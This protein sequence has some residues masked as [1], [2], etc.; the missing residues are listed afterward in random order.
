MKK[1]TNFFELLGI[2][3]IACSLGLFLFARIQI[4]NT[5]SKVAD[6]TLKIEAVLPAVTPGFPGDY[7]DT[8]MPVLQVDEKDYIGL[9]KIPAYGLT[10]PIANEWNSFHVFSCPARFYGSAYDS[11]MIIGGNDQSGQFDF[12]DRMNPGDNVRI[13]DMIGSE[14]SYTVDRIDRSQSVAY[15][16]LASG[17]YPLTLFVRKAYSTEYILVRCITAF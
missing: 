10:L 5:R 3:L 17:G 9:L 6:I 1:R 13:T 16:K 8:T 2:L 15:E 7:A 4:Q 11:T 14:F 12:F